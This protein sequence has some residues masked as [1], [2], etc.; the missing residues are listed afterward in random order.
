MAGAS[1]GGRP[2]IRRL[3][4]SR[5]RTAGLTRRPLRLDVRGKTAGPALALLAAQDLRPGGS[6]RRCHSPPW[7][8]RPT[9]PTTTAVFSISRWPEPPPVLASPPRSRRT[10]DAAGREGGGE[11]MGSPSPREAR[12]RQIIPLPPRSAA[13]PR[14]AGPVPG[15]DRACGPPRPHPIPGRRASRPDIAGGLPRRAN[16]PGSGQPGG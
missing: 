1:G 10:V 12:R 5:I 16:H 2:M 8:R 4:P 15:R 14:C 6:A 3:L 13:G 7:S 11:R 9:Q